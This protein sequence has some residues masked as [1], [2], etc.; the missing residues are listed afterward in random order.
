MQGTFDNVP[1]PIPQGLIPR[2]EYVA[3]CLKPAVKHSRTGAEQVELGFQ[4][5]DGPYKERW[6]YDY[7]TSD[8]PGAATDEKKRKAVM[9]GLSYLKGF[10]LALGL[11]TNIGLQALFQA[12]PRSNVI[13]AVDQEAERMGE[14]GVKYPARNRIRG[15]RQLPSPATVAAVIPTPFASGGAVAPMPFAAVATPPAAAAQPATT[16]RPNSDAP[17]PF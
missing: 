15:F 10:V 2:G 1:D 3:R 14:G 8:H 16:P 17:M 5:Q 7:A 11:P 4:I 13:I 12:A 9:I 6:V